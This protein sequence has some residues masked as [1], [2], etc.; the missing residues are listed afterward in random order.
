MKYASGWLWPWLEI[1][2]QIT[3]PKS[4][5]ERYLLKGTDHILELDRFIWT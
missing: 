1:T 3:K 4:N 2:S 5:Q